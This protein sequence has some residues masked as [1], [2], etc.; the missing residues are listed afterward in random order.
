M[1]FWMTDATVPQPWRTLGITFATLLF[2][3]AFA[4]CGGDDDDAA[5]AT[6]SRSTPATTQPGS[7]T[8]AAGTPTS[9]AADNAAAQR[10]RNTTY[11][12]SMLRDKEMGK[13][14]ARVVMEVYEDFQ[15]P[16]CLNFTVQ[17]EPEI[18]KDYIETGKVRFVFRNFPIL[19]QESSNAAIAA[20]CAANQGQFWPYHK[21]LF[22]VQAE[23]GQ[24]VREQV[25][26]GRFADARLKAYADEI[27][28]DRAAFD[29]C[30]TS[31]ETSTA[32]SDEVRAGVAAGV[33]GT[34]GILINGQLLAGTPADVAG[35]KKLLDD[36]VAG[37]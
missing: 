9:S 15:C 12:A 21:K 31:P 1:D 35:W 6:D 23:A 13:T 24:L 29:A 3:L 19:G 11:P 36:R 33:R 2:A 14:D 26:V 20:Q 30:L 25:N 37:R 32:V 18:I 8:A 5:P 10:I 16:H 4:A 17:V 7:R 27:K 22:L 28:L 34:P